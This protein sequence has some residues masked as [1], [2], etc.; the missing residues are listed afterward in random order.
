MLGETT[1]F[2][3]F[4]KVDWTV[5]GAAVKKLPGL[6]FFYKSPFFDGLDGFLPPA[7]HRDYIR[8]FYQ[9]S[10]IFGIRNVFES[11]LTAARFYWRSSTDKEQGACDV[12][13]SAHLLGQDREK[14]A[15]TFRAEN[16]SL[17]SCQDLSGPPGTTRQL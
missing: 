15:T 12:I 1:E 7:T 14:Y 4:G 8:V 11:F 2:F 9:L 3:I 10:Q 16:V 6:R 5:S 17:L 13:Q